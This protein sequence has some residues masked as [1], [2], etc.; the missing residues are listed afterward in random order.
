MLKETGTIHAKPAAS[1]LE[2]GIKV[3]PNEGEP[4]EDVSRYRRLVG[5]LICLTV[6]RPGLS[7]AVSMVSQFM[8]RENSQISQDLSCKRS[9]V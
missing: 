3:Q 6:T 5:K 1:P 2:V 8:Q 9:M 4:F 7:F